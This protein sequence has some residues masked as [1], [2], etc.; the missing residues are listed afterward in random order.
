VRDAAGDVDEGE[1]TELAIGAIEA[2]R[3]LG[4]QLEYQSGALGGEFPKK[5]VG[6]FRKLG[7]LKG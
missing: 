4:G 3:E 7:F 2:G 5:R 1:V 6:N